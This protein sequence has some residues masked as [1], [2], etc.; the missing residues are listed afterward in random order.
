M[1]HT[2]VRYAEESVRL[3]RIAGDSRII[4]VDA[5]AGI[6]LWETPKGNYWMPKD[7]QDLLPHLLAEQALHRKILGEQLDASAGQ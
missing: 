7:Q 4:G 3:R 2:A 5:A 6:D 1:P